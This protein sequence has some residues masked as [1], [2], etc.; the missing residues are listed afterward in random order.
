MI[1]SLTI[2]VSIKL[3]ANTYRLTLLNYNNDEVLSKSKD[4][5]LPTYSKKHFTM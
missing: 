5:M 2:H 1:V 3:E 4:T